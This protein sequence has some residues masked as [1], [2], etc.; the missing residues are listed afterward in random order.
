P[1]DAQRLAVSV[2][3]P[4]ISRLQALARE[5]GVAVCFGFPER[6]SDGLFNSMAFLDRDG[7][8]PV[9]YRKIHLWVTERAW[10]REGARLVSF[11]LDGQK[12]GMWVCYDSRFPEV[13]RALAVHGV[14]VALV[15][16]AWF[17]PEAEWELT[18]RA[19]ALDNGIFAAGAAAQGSFGKDPFHGKSIIVDPHGS[20][21]ASADNRTECVIT[22]ECDEAAV[23]SFRRRLPLLQDARPASC[24]VEDQP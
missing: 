17:G 7:R 1:S 18:M 11:S 5:N 24:V 4:E 14:T 6:S 16:S 21:L 12:A 2:D 23:T 13:A 20:I 8:K 3:G 19:R 9:V 22:A 15:G 10:A